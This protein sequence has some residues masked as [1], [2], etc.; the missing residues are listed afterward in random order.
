MCPITKTTSTRPVTAM[1]IFLPIVDRYS[2]NA[3]IDRG[4]KLDG[5]H[6]LADRFSALLERCSLICRELDLDDLLEPILA[7]LA[8]HAEEQPL[9]PV[10]ALEPRRARKDA[11]LI[12]HDR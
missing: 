8:G 5:A 12:V 4:L 1:I 7:E 9:H 3:H 11:P 6:R 10:L 2:V